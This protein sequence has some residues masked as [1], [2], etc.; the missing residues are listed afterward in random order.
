VE[1]D[2]TEG[3]DDWS[4]AAAPF[5]FSPTTFSVN[6]GSLQLG[7]SDF[8]T[9]GFWQ[10]PTNA[11]PDVQNDELLAVRMFMSTD[12]ADQC[13]VPTVRVRTNAV[14]QGQANVMDINSAKNCENAPDADGNAYTVIYRP[15]HD[16]LGSDHFMSFDWLFFDPFDAGNEAGVRLDRA[17]VFRIAA[18]NVET[19]RTLVRQYTF[20]ADEE[21]WRS[22]G[23]FFY[24]TDPVF[25]YTGGGLKMTATTR[26]DT[27]GFWNSLPTDVSTQSGVLYVSD[28]TV[29]T[30]LGQDNG[31]GG[32][33]RMRFRYLLDNAEGA[34]LMDV[35]IREA[36]TRTYEVYYLPPQHI[37][38]S[39]QDGLVL[40][41]DYLGFDP[42]TADGINVELTEWSLYTVPIPVLP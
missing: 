2:F 24:F 32:S 19:S 17:E 36:F 30:D 18:C 21:G 5:T 12:I 4:T 3:D 8:F 7:P 11:I 20:D 25:E 35:P 37:E 22:G 10:S 34:Q 23:A 27:Y 14:N 28:V 1:Y 26:V 29:V 41:I 39:D 15:Q 9:Y 6:P 42:F 40:A 16:G 13:T 33:P 38:G 31:E